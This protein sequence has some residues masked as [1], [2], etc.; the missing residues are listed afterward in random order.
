MLGSNFF[1]FFTDIE[2][3]LVLDKNGNRLGKVFDLIVRTNEAYPKISAIVISKGFFKKLFAVIP[4]ELLKP[5]SGPEGINANS[6]DFIYDSG[7]LTFKGYYYMENDMALRRDILDQQIVD[8]FNRKVV[9]VN[10]I[11][12]LKAENNL[13]IAHVD[14]GMRGLVRR[15]GAEK[16][17]DI[18]TKFFNPKTKYLEKENFIS[19]KFVQ[20]L[21]IH[22]VKGTLTLN[23]SQKDLS[24][25]PAGDIG[26]MML[27]LDVYERGALFKSLDNDLRVGVLS[28]VDLEMQKA[29]LEELD[30]KNVV[31]IFNK[32]PSDKAT[33]LLGAMPEKEADE[34]LV[35]MESGR[36][37]KL[38]AL[39]GHE[40]DSAGGLMT[41]EFITLRGN[42]TVQDAIKQIKEMTGKVETIYYG[43]IVDDTNHLIG[44]TTFRHLLFADPQKLI[45]EIMLKR[46]A[47]VH[48]ADTARK[49]S[50]LFDKY[51]LLA[52]PVVNHENVIQ[53]IIT[54]DDILSHIIQVAYKK[55]TRKPKL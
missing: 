17:A 20:P 8:T 32:M 47:S 6:Y 3:K 45:S 5:N 38:S 53:G 48:I 22:P 9:R 23:V 13:H 15:L 54:V 40:V 42:I 50:F 10:D 26:E 16:I 55:S 43:Y 27:D 2:K 46:P 44:M 37:K 18:I 51:N 31:D 33:D 19:W 28:E 12:L 11:H 7:P 35:L 24:T 34:L 1:T 52:I 41:T 30:T 39:L 49:A 21:A 29:L 14:V 25:I 36:A 4:W